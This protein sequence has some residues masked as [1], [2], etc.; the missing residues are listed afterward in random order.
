MKT[1]IRIT[2]P[3][4]LSED[5]VE[6]VF[7]VVNEHADIVLTSAMDEDGEIISDEVAVM[8]YQY[9][10][11]CIYEIQ[12]GADTDRSDAELIVKTLDEE[13]DAT[14]NFEVEIAEEE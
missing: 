9:E 14:I 7:D 10:G 2:T 11:D 6:T 8:M 4:P 1:Y 12:V 5:D 13:L 3:T